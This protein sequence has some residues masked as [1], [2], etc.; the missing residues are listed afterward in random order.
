MDRSRLIARH[1]QEDIHG[2]KHKLIF[3]RRTS[4][5]HRL[6]QEHNGGHSPRGHTLV[7][8]LTAL[9]A[10]CHTGSVW[11]LTRLSSKN[12][13][14]IF[15]CYSALDVTQEVVPSLLCKLAILVLESADLCAT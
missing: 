10:K 6:Q 14:S 8:Q 2:C 1:S 11:A 13:G 9:F 3:K 4:L 15:A 12:L 7:L 5:F